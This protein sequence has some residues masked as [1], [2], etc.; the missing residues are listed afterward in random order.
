MPN[1]RARLLAVLVVLGGSLTVA[2]APPATAAPSDSLWFDGAP[3]TVRDGR[4][5]DGQGREI[6]LRG[7]NVSGETKLEENG[8]LPFASVADARKS[9][10]ALRA[11]GGGNAV[12]FLLSWA[13]AEPVRGQ[14][15]TAYLAAAT[16]Q[17]RAF[18]DAGIRV[19]PD[20]H[21]D[22]FS[23]YLF[24]TDSWYTGD[25]APEWAV[26]AGSYPKESCGICLLWGQ[27]ITQNGA[28][29][30]AQYD[31]WHNA[32]GVQD[33]FLATAQSTMA[34]LRRH[35]SDAEFAGIAGFD[36]YN[37]PYAG[38][39]DSGQTSRTWE[40]D[41]LWPFY[42]RFRAR[43]DAAGWQ[44]KP[45]LVEPNLFW[46]ANISTQKQEGGLLDAGTL[47]PDYVFNTH[48]YDQKAISGILMWGKAADGQYA[49][50]FAAVRDR[51]T[52]AGTAAVVSE[53][54]HPLSG[55]V[56]DK[57]PT[58][59]KA[60]YQALDSRLPGAGWWTRPASSG[61]VLSGTQWQWD[62]YHGRHHEPM[63]GNPG[64]VLT[65]GDAW[66][67][68]DLS[69][70][71][72]DDSG[73]V[74]LRQDA[75]LLDRLYPSATAGTALAF[76]YE[77]R[78]RD[79]STTLTWN[80]VP[81][82]LPNVAKLVGSG[83]YGLLVWRSGDGTAPTELHLPASFPTAATTVVSDLGAVH[84]PPA[85]TSATPVAVAAEPGG[86]GSRRLLLTDA[87]S[88]VLHYALVTNGTAA[89]SADLL[90]AAKAELAGWAAARF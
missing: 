23:R 57:A 22:L 26:D 41:L 71:R 1:F 46:N 84:A 13:H 47:G 32:H 14:V 75:R 63:N 87:D 68:E 28:V 38:G 16:E 55:T 35:L 77:D 11:L 36:P 3:L 54:G 10:A 4:F 79:G 48:F 7:Y 62:L 90:D 34:H 60:M 72:L 18:L 20:F 70:V 24:D 78:S 6:V 30:K 89:P 56:S 8:G 15:D 49:A 59:L 39:Y 58:V 66:N 25:G 19:Q 42:V 9:A 80:P 33:A 64:K 31:F 73:S 81:T 83:Q 88:G 5:T 69:A 2:G 17:I 50:D 27:N 82:S 51:A 44:D 86:T 29:R 74:A 40:R 61:P 85:Y 37:E 21:Q 53:F 52:A 12:R 67:D 45:A 76:T 43:M 65:A